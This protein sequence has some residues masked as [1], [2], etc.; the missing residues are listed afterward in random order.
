MAK[1]QPVSAA[2]KQAPGGRHRREQPRRS[3]ARVSPQT[4]GASL[5]LALLLGAPIYAAWNA[6]GHTMSRPFV[7]PANPYPTQTATNDPAPAVDLVANDPPGQPV[8]VLGP[9]FR[10]SSTSSATFPRTTPKESPATSRSDSPV[11]TAG[12]PEAVSPT[13]QVQGP[14]ATSSPA[15]PPPSSTQAEL[16][17]VQST[18]SVV[19]TSTTVLPPILTSVTSIL[20]ISVVQAPPPD[21]T[22]STSPLPVPPSQGGNN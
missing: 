13:V 2:P 21:P 10:T 22:G 16:P 12:Q 11:S 17:T 15:T 14:A 5:T 18:T 4:M 19:P 8:Y 7:P 9:D 1:H 6:P 20:P 3:F